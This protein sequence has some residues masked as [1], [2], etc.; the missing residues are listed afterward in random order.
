MR[1]EL[2]DEARVIGLA[3]DQRFPMHRLAYDHAG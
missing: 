1:G 3:D 2:S